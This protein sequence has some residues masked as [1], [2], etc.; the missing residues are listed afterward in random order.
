[1]TFSSTITRRLLIG[2]AVLIAVFA[3]AASVALHGLNEYG[4]EMHALRRRESGARAVLLLGRAIYLRFGDT[5]SQAA[6]ARLP[7][8]VPRRE[9]LKILFQ[10]IREHA[11]DSADRAL[12]AQIETHI[13]QIRGLIDP[14]SGDWPESATRILEDLD[15]ETQRLSRSFTASIDRL[16]ETAAQYVQST[17]SGVLW[18][19]MTE[20]ILTIAIGL[21]FGR[22]ISRPLFLLEEGAKRL[23][24]G[25]LSTYIDIASSDEFG[26]LAQQ[27]NRMTLTLREHREELLKGERLAAIG[28]FST[29]VAHEINNPLGVILG[30]VRVL[31]KDASGQ[32]DTDLAII[33]QETRRCQEI[34]EGL[35]DLARPI[36]EDP[37]PADLLV[38]TQDAITWLKT[39]AL[40]PEITFEVTGSGFV[41]GSAKKL[42]QVLTNLLRNAA[43]ASGPGG[44]VQVE[45]FQE[46]D[47]NMILTVHDSGPGL[48]GEDMRR[49]FE[50]F[51]TT[52]R[53]GTG[54]G[55]AVSLAIV[56]GH[57][58]RL[59][60]DTMKGG[61]AA[62]KMTLPPWIEAP[63]AT[64]DDRPAKKG[65]H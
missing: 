55:L 52:K 34:V 36:R 27:F 32:S 46:R 7:A 13:D 4:S 3:V 15:E 48:A 1:M 23:A 44:R 8:Q 26:R 53:G 22:T 57:G 47:Q 45:I 38:I 39:R 25:D 63:R 62:F 5:S 20:M 58:G 40:A 33:E 65:P 21:Y 18:F 28:R 31:R 60:A 14:A 41:A 49:L 64:P 12:I 6:R 24:G 54:L 2:S 43:E 19:L 59:E 56:Q 9:E 10:Q 61:G 30:Y 50:P 51:Y 29:G 35:L 11:T 16:D 42:G 37:K 17:Y